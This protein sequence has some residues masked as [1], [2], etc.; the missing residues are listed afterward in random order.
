MHMAG[1]D[2][3]RAFEGGFKAQ[4]IDKIDLMHRSWGFER[5]MNECKVSGLQLPGWCKRGRD[6]CHALFL[7]NKVAADEERWLQFSFEPP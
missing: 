4:S 1:S 3:R 6:G 2:F 7:P 5:L